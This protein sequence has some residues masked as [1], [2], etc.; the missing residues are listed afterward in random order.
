MASNIQIQKICEYCRKEFTAQKTVSKCCSDQCSKKAYKAR[1]RASKIEAVENET[2]KIKAVN[3]DNLKAKEFLT[4]RDTAILL[5]SSVRT[6]YRMIE[7]GTL[8]AVNFSER[9]TLIKR[10][11]IDSIFLATKPQEPQQIA[12]NDN[13]DKFPFELSDCYSTSEIRDKFKISDIALNGLIK[14]NNIPKIKKGWYVFVPK[15]AIDKLYIQ[16]KY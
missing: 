9:K 5:N 16:S 2:A 13:P 4:V 8:N 7:Q 10:S 15:E 14:R 1:M 6:I 3:L 12:A 11:D